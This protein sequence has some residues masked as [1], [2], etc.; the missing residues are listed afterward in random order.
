MNSLQL[1]QQY[2]NREEV[3]H[4]GK[5]RMGLSISAT[6]RLIKVYDTT[7]GEAIG[8]Y[9][10]SRKI[11][12]KLSESLDNVG[13]QLL[14]RKAWS[15]DGVPDIAV[16]VIIAHYSRYAKTPQP[17]VIA[18]ADYLIAHSMREV[19]QECYGLSQEN[20]SQ[21]S[22][23]LSAKELLEIKEAL[24]T[25]Q[26]IA[27]RFTEFL[28]NVKPTH[29]GLF[30][31]VV[32][33]SE[34]TYQLALPPSNKQKL[35]TI[36]DFLASKRVQLAYPALCAFRNQVALSYRCLALTPPTKVK[37]ELDNWVNAYRDCDLP[38]LDNSLVVIQEAFSE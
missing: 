18:L 7:L 20:E 24:V 22:I 32:A 26:K 6:A 30:N 13:F 28:G 27:S 2:F 31:V 23:T 37:N 5:G 3:K 8:I 11:N 12:K 34:P 21:A 29:P 17:E 33:M 16:A 10:D 9:A 15:K 35:H 14:A 1:F 36:D 25:T 19:L 38:I 4:Y